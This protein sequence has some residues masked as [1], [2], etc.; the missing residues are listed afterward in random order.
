M[1]SS[2]LETQPA[3][4]EAEE[5]P[6]LDYQHQYLEMEHSEDENEADAL[7]SKPP[8]FE[9]RVTQSQVSDD[10]LDESISLINSDKGSPSRFTKKS[11]SVSSFKLYSKKALQTSI[12]S[13]NHGVD[14][15]EE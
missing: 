1:H 7:I 14:I 12:K 10:E 13:E 15:L 2:N 4:H 11:A 9:T 3:P 6:V 5:R 8:D